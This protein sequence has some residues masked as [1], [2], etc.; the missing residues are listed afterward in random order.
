VAVIWRK[1][2]Q[3]INFDLLEDGWPAVG[4]ADAQRRAAR[5]LIQLID[6]LVDSGDILPYL[7]TLHHDLLNEHAQVHT[8]LLTY[9]PGHTSS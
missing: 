6:W 2:A 8:Y 9:L 1:S 7:V 5:R 3:Q 4:S